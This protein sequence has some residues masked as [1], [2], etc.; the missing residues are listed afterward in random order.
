MIDLAIV[1]SLQ[2]WI[3]WSRNGTHQ[4]I[5]IVFLYFSAFYLSQFSNMGVKT[6]G[7]FSL[8]AM[9]ILALC[10]Y[11]V[12]KVLDHFDK[13]SARDYEAVVV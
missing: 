12:L 3:N 6:L 4:P 2:R 8:T 10:S 7:Y 5:L 11:L 1:D 13:A 9:E